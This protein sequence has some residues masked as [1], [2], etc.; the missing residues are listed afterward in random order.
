ML[1]KKKIAVMQNRKN[2]TSRFYHVEFHIEN[3]LHVAELLCAHD[4]IRIA[5][6]GPAYNRLNGCT[7]AEQ[8]VGL[9]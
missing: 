1:K 2:S 8:I 5:K 3:R 7:G 4:C 6:H 9:F